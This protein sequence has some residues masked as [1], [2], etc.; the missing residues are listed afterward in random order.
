[1][2]CESQHDYRRLRYRGNLT[3]D[4]VVCTLLLTTS[5]DHVS[6]RRNHIKPTCEKCETSGVYLRES[7]VICIRQPAHVDIGSN[8]DGRV[9]RD[10]RVRI[11][12]QKVPNILC[13]LIVG[14]L[15]A[16]QR[17]FHEIFLKLICVSGL[18]WP[19][20]VVPLVCLLASHHHLPKPT[21]TD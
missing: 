18:P 7:L 11:G 4:L 6:K 5:V 19:S 12:L 15:A 21:R 17:A 2:A 9:C 13:K 3:S 20:M 1:M 10:M 8:H 14:N 16:F